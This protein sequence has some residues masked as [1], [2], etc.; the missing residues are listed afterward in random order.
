[1]FHLAP[2]GEVEH[3]APDYRQKYLIPT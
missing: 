1:L 3:H 2:S